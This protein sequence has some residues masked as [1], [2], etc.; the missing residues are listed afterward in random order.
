MDGTYWCQPSSPLQ[1]PPG[2]RYAAHTLLVTDK[3]VCTVHGMT[4]TKSRVGGVSTGDR[5][6]L[7]P[8]W[9]LTPQATLDEARG[10]RERTRSA[11]RLPLGARWP[12]LGEPVRGT[13]VGLLQ[14]ARKEVLP[15][16]SE[17]APNPP[18]TFFYHGSIHVT[19]LLSKRTK[20]LRTDLIDVKCFLFIISLYISFVIS[21]LELSP[22]FIYFLYFFFCELF[23]IFCLF[24]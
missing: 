2:W 19:K 8:G 1:V 15:K 23:H 11:G 21:D 22:M 16:A 7:T 12:S 24:I 3:R 20:P 17:G 4:W 13:E 6:N 14:F 18:Q 10:H 5:E 9:L